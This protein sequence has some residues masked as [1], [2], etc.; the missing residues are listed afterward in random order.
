MIAAAGAGCKC[1][2]PFLGRCRGAEEMTEAPEETG[3][4]AQSRLAGPQRNVT[5]EQDPWWP[6]GTDVTVPSGPSGHGGGRHVPPAQSGSDRPRRRGYRRS[7][8][9]FGISGASSFG[10]SLCFF[11]A[12]KVGVAI[13]FGAMTALAV[14]ITLIY[15]FQARTLEADLGQ[16]AGPSSGSDSPLQVPTPLPGARKRQRAQV[17]L[18]VLLMLWGAS[19][20]AVRL[21]VSSGQP[22]S[23]PAPTVPPAVIAQANV[24]M[25]VPLMEDSLSGVTGGGSIS[26]LVDAFRTTLNMTSYGGISVATSWFELEAT[27]YSKQIRTEGAAAAKEDM[28]SAV[29]QEC[30]VLV[31]EG[32]GAHY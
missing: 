15:R 18:L 22:S 25:C 17:V 14:P 26:Q 24:A 4:G 11:L 13:C 31:A 28:D 6:T 21:A 5:G 30:P 32:F 7:M 9:L 20:G 19:L 2:E 8:T 23:G 10:A 12:G 27:R 1:H 29:T 3:G 16:G